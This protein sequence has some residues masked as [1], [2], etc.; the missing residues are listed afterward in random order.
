MRRGERARVDLER[1]DSIT[2]LYLP[3][4]QPVSLSLVVLGL[5]VL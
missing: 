2:T 4:S 3:S 1:L 5:P